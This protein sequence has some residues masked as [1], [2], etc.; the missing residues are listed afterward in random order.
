MTHIPTVAGYATRG[1]VYT[2]LMYHL[3]ECQ[4]LAAVMS[5]LHNT[6]DS[7]KDKLMARAWLQVSEQFKMSR[8]TLIKLASGGLQ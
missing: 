2:K 6:E 7:H 8:K 1:E 3:N 5:H 4:D